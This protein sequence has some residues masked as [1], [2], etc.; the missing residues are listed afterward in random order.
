MKQNTETL[1][2]PLDKTGQSENSTCCVIIWESSEDFG[3]GPSVKAMLR[4]V[5]EAQ[6]VQR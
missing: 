4:L 6:S 2:K 3:S 5:L 1:V